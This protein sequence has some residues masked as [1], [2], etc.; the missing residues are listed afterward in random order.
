MTSGTP[1]STSERCRIIHADVLDGLCGLPDASVYACVT[2]PPYWALR[3]Y[4]D[5]EHPDK[6]KEIG[7][8]L[9]P[10]AH[11]ARMVEVFREVWR[12]LWDDGCFWLNYG[13]CYAASPGQRKATD[14]AGDKQASNAGSVSCASRS[15]AG[16]KP[17]DLVGMPW[18]VAFAL[19]AD[20]WY[21]RSASPWVKRSAMPESVTDRPTSA[22]EY[23]FLLTKQPTYYF[24]MEAVRRKQ[25]CPNANGMRFGGGK[26]PGNGVAAVCYSGNVYDA[27]AL[28]GRAWRNSDFWFDS[29][30]MLMQGE[31]IV[32]FDVLPEPLKAK[33]YAAFPRDLV[34]PCVLASCPPATC[35]H[36]GA[37][38]RRAVERGVLVAGEGRKTSTHG[39]KGN[40][41]G[42]N[43]WNDANFKPGHSYDRQT[44]GWQPGCSCPHTQ[45]DTVPGVVLDPFMG[46]GTTGMVALELGM[47][48]VGIE[49]SE[50]YIE[51]AR[52]RIKPFLVQEIIRFNAEPDQRPVE[53][54][55]EVLL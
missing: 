32:G 40:R 41:N 9:T 17:K 36:C 37:G 55:Q 44:L 49:L 14:K 4:L 16:L 50:A 45:A 8:E 28:G 33:H 7:L 21:L 52:E 26:Y 47:H 35:P 25:N 34:R 54:V 42:D 31:E 20:G 13:D 12:V 19:Q 18:R 23:M 24:D 27:S 5:S 38:W 6:P 15:C 51:I 46:S 39:A 2:S 48:F 53:P 22:L 43:H 30:G 1:R 29:V 11:V 3:S 10:E